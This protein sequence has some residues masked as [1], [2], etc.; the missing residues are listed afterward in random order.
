MHAAFLLLQSASCFPQM[1]A[2]C[3]PQLSSCHYC[4]S[5]LSRPTLSPQLPSLA[6]HYEDLMNAETQGKQGKKGQW[7][8]K[9][10]PKPHVNDVSLPGTSSR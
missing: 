9:E 2:S 10:P 7:S 8:S 6:A 4:P 1:L 3:Q 5:A